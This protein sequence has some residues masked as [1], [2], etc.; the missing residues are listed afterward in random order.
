MVERSVQLGEFGSQIDVVGRR[1]GANLVIG[2]GGEE[3]E[4]MV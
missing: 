2:E 3:G 1:R 4:E